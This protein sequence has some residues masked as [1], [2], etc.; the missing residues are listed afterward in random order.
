MSSRKSKFE[1][2]LI[3]HNWMWVAAVFF[4]LSSLAI[5][6]H[7]QSDQTTVIDIEN[8]PT[9]Q[10]ILEKIEETKK[11]IAELE[12]KQANLILESNELDEKRA[13]AKSS[14]ENDL[15]QWENL[16]SEYSSENVFARF[17]DTVQTNSTKAVFWD[18]YDFTQAKIQA[19]RDAFSQTVNSGGDFQ[20]AYAAYLKAAEIKRIEMIQVN[21]MYNV[22][23]GLAYYNQQILFNPDGQLD[24]ELSGEQL[25]KYYEDFRTNPQYLLANPDDDAS[26]EGIGISD[27]GTECRVGYALVHRYNEDDYVCVTEQTAE[28]WQRHKMGIAV[29]RDIQATPNVISI[30]QMNHDRV[31]EKVTS[32]NS[33]IQRMHDTN[34]TKKEEMDKK[35]D[36]MVMN[37]DV[38]QKDEEKKVLA[39]IANDEMSAKNFSDQME[40][41]R[42]KYNELEKTMIKEKFQILEIIEKSHK[43]ELNLL[44]DRYDDDP[45]MDVIWNSD[46]RTYNAVMST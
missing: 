15:H 4:S 28:M 20:E 33:K 16:W 32:V 17:V 29:D 31:Q 11:W 9:A 8:N 26:R 13:Q 18:H 44:A 22:M 19:G 1:P 2:G 34:E 25:R 5:P 38:Q 41:I 12:E 36:L 3:D 30:Q 27:L 46:R 42:G 10:D 37:M 14:L 43:R 23:H 45:E 39:K 35:H 40:N 7:A 24:L 6:A 21:S